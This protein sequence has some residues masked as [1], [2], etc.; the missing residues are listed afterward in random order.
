MFLMSK[1]D[2][3]MKFHSFSNSILLKSILWLD[4]GWL[5]QIYI[6]RIRK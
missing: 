5:D 2:Y 6:D 4:N 1:F 3:S